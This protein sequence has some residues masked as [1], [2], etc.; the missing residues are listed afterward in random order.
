MHKVASIFIV[1]HTVQYRAF[2]SWDEP[3]L[4]AQ[5]TITL[6][7]RSDTVSLSNM[8]ASSE[9]P[10]GSNNSPGAQNEWKVTVFEK[11]PPMSSYLVAFANGQFEYLESSYKSPLSGRI[12]PLRIYATPDS[13]HQ[14]QFALEVKE[15]TLPLYEEV[16]DVEF[17]LPK[18][19]TLVAADFD[20]G[21]MENWG[22]ITGRTTAF[23]FDPKKSSLAAKKR[24]AVVQA[25]EVAHMWFGDITTMS[26]WDALWLNE[27]FATLM[28]EVIILNKIFP[29]WR[30][31][32]AFINDHLER[33]LQLD[34]QRSSHPIQVDCP[35]AAMI[36][37][38]RYFP[39]DALSYSK[40]A[41]MLRMLSQYVGEEKFLKGVSIYLKNHLYA[42]SEPVDLWNGIAE[43][44]GL[45][46]ARMMDKWV[47]K[48]G[49]PVLTV[50]EEGGKLHI[51][52]DRFLATGDPTEEENQTVWYIPLTILSTDSSGKSV[53]DRSIVLDTRQT[54]IS[55]DTT[56][57]FKLN[58]GT[59]GVFR[60]AYEPERLKLLGQWAAQKN[61]V[62]TLEDRMGLVSDAMVLAKAGVGATSGALDLIASLKD[63]TEHL[64]WESITT[65]LT[66][67]RKL[68]W[69]HPEPVR[70]AFNAFLQT[71]YGPLV[72][73]FGYTYLPDESADVRQLRTLAIT[74]AAAAEDPSV[75][76]EL[77][78]RFAHFQETG[79]DSK[80]P[81]DLQQVT[82]ATAVKYGGRKEY[83]TVKQLWRKP[84]TPSTKISALQG[85]T[86][87]LD[88]NI[89]QD[90]LK[91]VL[92]EVPLQDWMYIFMGLGANRTTRRGVT[93]F[94]KENYA[95]ILKRFEGNFSLSYIIKFVFESYTTEEDAQD[96]ERFF[97]DKDISKYELAYH[98][99][100]DSIRA[101]A[102]WLKRSESDIESW[103]AKQERSKL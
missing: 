47:Y 77:K 54:T 41:S 48:I 36:N 20:A 80:I 17:P 94:F 27:G 60:V 15:K 95:E 72:T 24:V 63:E 68:L 90:T 71:L 39:F 55:L 53:I 43:A 12:R 99:A 86:S 34:A 14:A 42:N 2:P 6:I 84:P 69:E 102:A 26:W 58:A 18:L 19:D 79:D 103:L 56:K 33:A 49:Y 35:D 97:K 65:Q 31:H 25:H 51:R 91:L 29:E 11:T 10:H 4:K 44:T 22:L 46:I 70:D 1:L 74:K 82:Y 5:Y 89:M 40:A 81:T 73:K 13:I 16:F 59:I 98:Q 28:G 21:A 8:P 32:S 76:E 45:D 30:P 78:S 92:E 100:L 7:S 62:F 23:L 88:L 96:T 85:L 75:I 87:S 61:S 38:V 3:L 66:M 37:Q 83:D 101:N 93:V 57:P 50:K 64:V 67:I 52:Q 9:V